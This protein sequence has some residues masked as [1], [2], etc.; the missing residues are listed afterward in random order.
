[1]CG[2]ED[3]T[4]QNVLHGLMSAWSG[5]KDSFDETN[6]ARW[7]EMHP[8]DTIVV[9]PDKPRNEAVEAVALF[10]DHCL[11]RCVPAVF[12]KDYSPPIP[13]PSPDAKIGYQ[14]LTGPETVYATL[15]G[16][17]VKVF[18]DHINVYIQVLGES[19]FRKTGKYKGIIRV[20]WETPPTPIP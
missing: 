14:I 13:R 10:S 9:L 19:L 3:E 1:M 4:R 6:P 18:D 8:P 15:Q 20:Y 16:P 12:D 17:N 7:T 11:D 2:S 5:G